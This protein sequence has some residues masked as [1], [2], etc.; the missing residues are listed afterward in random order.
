MFQKPFYKLPAFALGIFFAKLY[1]KIIAYRRI[2][3][4]QERKKAHPCVDRIHHSNLIH[5]LMLTSGLVLVATN[6]LIGH[7]A[8]ADAYSWSM[9]EN[10]AYNTMTRPTYVIGIFLILF[11]FFTGGFTLGKEFMGRS[12]FRVLGKLT[13]ESAMIT[14]LMIQLIYSQLPQGLFISFNK[15][16]ELGI[17]NVVLVMAVSLALYILFEY[18][19]RRL[20]EMTLLKCLKV[21]DDI[22]VAFVRRNMRPIFS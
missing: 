4:A 16:L 11:V 7:S 20:G 18:P 17:G 21:D 22:F 3:D 10:I 13:F 12:F 9:A 15:V 5:A 19:M 6:L 14:P 2:N 1:M 8:I